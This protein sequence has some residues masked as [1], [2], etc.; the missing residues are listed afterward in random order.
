M[1][2]HQQTSGARPGHARGRNTPQQIAHGTRDP[3]AACYPACH[4]VTSPV[5]SGAT[6][7][8]SVLHP[9]AWPGGQDRMSPEGLRVTGHSLGLRHQPTA[10]SAPRP[11]RQTP[12]ASRSAFPRG[13]P[14]PPPRTTGEAPLRLQPVPSPGELNSKKDGVSGKDRFLEEGPRGLGKPLGPPKRLEDGRQKAGPFLGREAAP[15]SLA[16]TGFAEKT[17]SLQSVWSC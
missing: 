11:R 1:N 5:R 10:P 13:I 7:P 3:G 9:A 15:S 2:G 4:P 14:G 16:P 6:R 8:A 12:F 17:S